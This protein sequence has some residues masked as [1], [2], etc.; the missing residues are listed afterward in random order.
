VGKANVVC[1]VVM[2]RMTQDVWHFGQPPSKFFG[3]FW[4]PD[5]SNV[6]VCSREPLGDAPP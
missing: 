2:F 3:F 6:R 1:V 4:D 5:K